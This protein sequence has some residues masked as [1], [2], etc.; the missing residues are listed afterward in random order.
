MADENKKGLSGYHRAPEVRTMH[1][2]R[3]LL[4]LA[5][6]SGKIS[7]AEAAKRTGLSR[8]QVHSLVN[9][10]LSAMIEAISPHSP[11]RPPKPER[12]RAL[13]A[14]NEELRQEN[15]RL[16]EQAQ[17]AER[18]L[19]AA[20]DM[21][22]VRTTTRIRRGRKPDATKAAEPEK[23]EDPDGARALL[24]KVEAM[25]GLGAR[26]PL[27]AVVAGVSPATLRR[28]QARARRRLLPIL[29]RG[30][31]QRP[32]PETAVVEQVE[33]KVRALRGQ[34]GAASL[35]RAIPGVSRRQAL[36]IKRQTLT[37][38]ERE[39]LARC[40][41]VR[42]LEPGVIRGFDAMH[43]ET[44]RDRRFLL[45]AADAAV[46]FRTTIVSAK[47][48]D[49]QSVARA[50]EDD[51]SMHGAP[52][53]WKRDRARQHATDEVQEV[54]DRFGV[55]VLQGPPHHPGFYGQLERQNREHRAWLDAV[56]VLDPD[57]L[58]RECRIMQN[59]FNSLVPRRRLGFRSAADAWFSR[60]KLALDRS[61]FRAEVA[62]L[63][64]RLERT[65]PS[66]DIAERFAIQA[67]LTHHGL[68]QVQKGA[69]ALPDIHPR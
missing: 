44:M 16:A 18:V 22:K 5:A 21:L 66:P 50:V 65:T 56:G 45:V 6:A 34:I 68:I 41:R 13:E 61:A 15:R 39:R 42:V 26:L 38:L 32:P 8:K 14:E 43:V 63:V 28:W 9:R 52:L 60:P 33:A 20:S 11:G 69:P 57:E 7:V 1:E 47:R 35:R 24:E 67:A 49:G 53:V 36:A 19:A 17:I 37:A 55:L 31:S 25:R 64:A 2:Q 4:I 58:E 40:E 3:L 30:A 27:C 62:E 59:A 46:P 54:L 51:F 48:Y 10:G 23:E 29:R 12:V